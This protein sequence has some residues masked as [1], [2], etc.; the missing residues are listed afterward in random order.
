MVI[1]KHPHTLSRMNTGLLIIDVQEKF[2]PVIPRFDDVVANIVRLV[3]TFQM[4]RMPIL[5]TEQYPK[6]LGNTVGVIRDQ[7]NLLEV[8][9][10][11]EC[12]CTS[13]ELFMKQLHKSGVKTLVVCG[14]ESHVC[15]NQTVLGLLHGGYTIH[16][17]ADAMGSRNVL[18]HDMALRKMLAEGAVPSTTEIVLFELAE[19]GGTEAFKNV[20]RLV[21][22]KLRKPEAVMAARTAQ[23]VPAKPAIDASAT[24]VER[25]T[26]VKTS[27]SRS[28]APVAQPIQA[29]DAP[30]AED[31]PVF[32]PSAA[33]SPASPGDQQADTADSAAAAPANGDSVL[34]PAAEGAPSIDGSEGDLGIDDLD[35]L[36]GEEEQ[37]R[38]PA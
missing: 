7:F 6:G 37:G 13:N 26:D 24:K 28:P 30:A 8:V 18:D 20:Q 2:Q 4:F 27:T 12:A 5:V 35:Q 33:S 16:A 1:D 36:L 31:V 29:A 23:A 17:V 38:K 3:L 34:S 32:E 21:K 11:L 9:E 22:S 25:A 19:K 10:K 15:V 14:I